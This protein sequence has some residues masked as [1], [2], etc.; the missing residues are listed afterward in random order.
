MMVYHLFAKVGIAACQLADRAGLRV[1]GTA[2]SDSGIQLLKS[3]GV[4]DVFNHKSEGYNKEIMVYS[5][6]Y[7]L[8]FHTGITLLDMLVGLESPTISLDSPTGT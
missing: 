6:H 2:G 3:V 4:K 8:Q 1:L 7:I 5:P